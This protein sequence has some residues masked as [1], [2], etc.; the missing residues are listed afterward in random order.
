MHP[1]RHRST[2]PLDVRRLHSS[3]RPRDRGQARPAVV[4]GGTTDPAERRAL[5]DGDA[6]RRNLTSVLHELLPLDDWRH[7]E[8]RIHVAFAPRAATSPPLAQLQR[9][10]L[11]EVRPALSAA[12]ALMWNDEEHAERCPVAAL[13]PVAD[14]HVRS[15]RDAALREAVLMTETSSGQNPDRDVDD[16]RAATAR[17]KNSEA[18]WDERYASMEQVWSGRPNAVL[19]TEVAELEPG[20]A[21]DV[22]CGEGTDAVWLARQGW[23]VTAL[24]VSQV[25]LE[26][27]A[28][29]AEDAEAHVQWVH[30]GLVEAQLPAGAFDL[31]SAQYPALL[32]SPSS[33]AESSLL[34]AVAPGGSCSSCIMPSLTRSRPRPTG[35]TRP[36]TRARRTSPPFSATTGRSTSRRHD[37]ATSLPAAGPT[38]PTTWYF[39][40]GVCASNT[41]TPRRSGPA[42][43]DRATTAPERRTAAGSPCRP[44]DPTAVRARR[45]CHATSV[46]AK[47]RLA[48]EQLVEAAS[49]ALFSSARSQ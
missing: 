47:A 28:L 5:A 11:T 16:L 43:R 15:S 4:V 20:R 34:A 36:T 14:Q 45:S 35:S 12:F 19:V 39:G 1:V 13:P 49:M 22:G 44:R 24:D 8:I 23:G 9:K 26:R 7:T 25:A 38:T 29:H 30:A 17:A 48:D 37:H 40:G 41:R 10:V 18:K 46:P 32:R 33:E 27:A 31:V 42:W 21:L 6:I 2:D 3:A